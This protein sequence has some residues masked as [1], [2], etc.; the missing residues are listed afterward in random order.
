MSD[1]TGC[2]AGIQTYWTIFWFNTADDAQ[3]FT[4]TYARY[5]SA[6]GDCC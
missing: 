2:K 3:T 6:F 4:A 1:A 5:L